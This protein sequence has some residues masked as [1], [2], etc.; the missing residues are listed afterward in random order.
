MAIKSDDKGFRGG[1]RLESH[2][3]LSCDMAIETAK[4]PDHLLYPMK[5][6]SGLRANPIVKAGDH[7]KSGRLLARFPDEALPP[8]RATSSGVIF[9]REAATPFPNTPNGPMIGVETDGRDESEPPFPPIPTEDQ[10]PDKVIERL[11][12][13]G[14]LGMGGAGFSTARKLGSLKGPLRFL[15]IN[16]AEC[17]PYLTCDERIILDR[18]EELIDDALQT[19]RIFGFPQILIAVE[20]QRQATLARLDDLIRACAL[21]TLKLVRLPD[22]YPAGGERQMIYAAS[23]I[24]IPIGRHPVDLGILCLNVQTLLAL[25]RAVNHGEIL[26]RRTVTVSGDAIHSPRNIEVRIGAPVNVLIEAA[27]GCQ[28]GR[29]H[30]VLGGPMMGFSVNNDAVPVM[31]TLS[32]LLLLS[33]SA[34][35]QPPESPCIRCG[36]CAEV[37]PQ[38]LLPQ[39]LNDHAKAHRLK[40]LNDLNL[41]NCIECACCDQVCPSHIPLTTH[42]QDAKKALRRY[43]DDEKMALIARKRHEARQERLRKEDAERQQESSERKTALGQRHQPKIQEALARARLKKVQRQLPSGDTSDEP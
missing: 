7:V 38:I 26:T 39:L 20:S 40:S 18:A 23:G 13:C 2:K 43:L 17:E 14:V 12:D 22:R 11:N 36:R 24:E 25:G 1:I 16:A 34:I 37:C 15:I 35:P 21:P 28:P 42:F 9:F 19:A 27:G 5:T 33:E 31:K 30:L 41:L 3:S 4:L 29:H 10:T 6:P 8:I 32:G